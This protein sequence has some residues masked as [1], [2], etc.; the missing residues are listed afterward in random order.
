MYGSVYVI[1]LFFPPRK[2]ERKDSV[3]GG[4][5][6][7]IIWKIRYICNIQKQLIYIWVFLSKAIVLHITSLYLERNIFGLHKGE[8][9]IPKGE[10]LNLLPHPEHFL[11]SSL[12]PKLRYF[13][14]FYLRLHY[15]EPYFISL[16]LSKSWACHFILKK[17]DFLC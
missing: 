13:C 12:T 14:Q 4:R 10:F 2:K 16:V 6:R 1:S 9:Q 5:L 8:A 15:E 11:S 7:V 17:I 3:K